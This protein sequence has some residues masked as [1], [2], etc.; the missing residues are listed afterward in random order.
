MSGRSQGEPLQAAAGGGTALPASGRMARDVRSGLL[1]RP[2]TL[3]CMYFYDDAGSDLFERITREP[4]YYQTRTEEAL[5]SEHAGMLVEALAPRE[6]VELGSGAGRKVRLLL[7]AMSARGLLERCLL[8]DV[9][10]LFLRT[11]VTRLRREY[12]GAE[13]RGM[14][15]D[16]QRD[17]PLLRREPGGPRRLVLFLAGTIG[18]LEPVEVP[19]FLA[20]VRALLAPGD[21]LLVGVDTVKDRAALEAAYNDR[22]GVTA[23]FNRNILRVLNR[24]LGADFRPERWEHV[25]FWDAERSWI[26]MRLRSSVDQHVSIPSLGLAF[27]VRRGE[28]LRTEVSAKYTRASFAARAAGTGLTLARWD[29]DGQGRFA[30]ALLQPELPAT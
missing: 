20:S 21:G 14:T 6:L 5:L 18:N 10:A 25:A 11:S 8:L 13:V 2:R 26:E 3:P 30:L 17:L 24:E 19:A 22:A 27:D 23:E 16:F 29:T 12:P 28:E 9:N 1:A 4:E 7:D 15:G